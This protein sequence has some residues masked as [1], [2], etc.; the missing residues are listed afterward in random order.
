MNITH[1]IFD[2]D[3]TLLDTEKL[4]EDALCMFNVNN[5]K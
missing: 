4:Y 1:C 5:K 2:L 3:G